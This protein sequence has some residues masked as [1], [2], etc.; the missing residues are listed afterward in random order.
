[1]SDIEDQGSF[2][3]DRATELPIFL[4]ALEEWGCDDTTEQAKAILQFLSIAV[5]VSQWREEEAG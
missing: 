2:R 1:M 3:A 4:D 5:G